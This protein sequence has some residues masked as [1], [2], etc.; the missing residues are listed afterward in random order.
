[1]TDTPDSED[2]LLPVAKILTAQTAARAKAPPHALFVHFPRTVP[3][4]WDPPVF[5]VEA[6]LTSHVTEDWNAFRVYDY[7]LSQRES[8]FVSYPEGFRTMERRD[9]ESEAAFCA[10][11][12]VAQHALTLAGNYEAW[13]S[14]LRPEERALPAELRVLRELEA[15]LGLCDAVATEERADDRILRWLSLSARAFAGESFEAASP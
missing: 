11:V 14:R 2:A 9:D 8:R 10:R 6:Q 4:V 5:Q 7:R 15:A 3:R 1:M 12:D 13:I